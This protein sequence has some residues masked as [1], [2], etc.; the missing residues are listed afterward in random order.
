MSIDTYTD[1]DPLHVT[2]WGVGSGPHGSA[3]RPV[4]SRAMGLCLYYAPVSGMP[5]HPYIGIMWG[6]GRGF[7][8]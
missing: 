4:T 1:I 5:H 6:D 7:V 8:Q 3:D 2:S